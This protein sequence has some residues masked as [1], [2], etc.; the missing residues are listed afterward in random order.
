MLEDGVPANGALTDEVT[1]V[2]SLLLG[3]KILRGVRVV[4]PF[5]LVCFHLVCYVSKALI[6]TKGEVRFLFS[7]RTGAI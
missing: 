4:Q 3:Q 1:R 5:R 6:S 7:N 2:S